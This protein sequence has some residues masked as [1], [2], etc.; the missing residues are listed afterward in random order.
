MNYIFNIPEEH[1]DRVLEEY[2]SHIDRL[3]ICQEECS[4]LIKAIS[5]HIRTMKWADD[6]V[7]APVREQI[8]EEMTHVAICLAMLKKIFSVDQSEINDEVLKK[9]YTGEKYLFKCTNE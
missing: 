1:V 4:E 8:V 2:D 5:K 6:S 9:A 7:R 3:Q